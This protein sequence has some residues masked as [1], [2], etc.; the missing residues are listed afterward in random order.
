[1][2]DNKVEIEVGIEASLSG[3]INRVLSGGVADAQ[4]IEAALNGAL[5][6]LQAMQAA[7]KKMG[8]LTGAVSRGTP[9]AQLINANTSGQAAN[10]RADKRLIETFEKVAR[11]LGSGASEA[12]M[13]KA[14]REALVAEGL[15][16]RSTS[17]TS[18]DFN[19]ATLPLYQQ[20]QAGSRTARN[21][22]LNADFD[23]AQ[24]ENRARDYIEHRRNR[25][26][27]ERFEDNSMRA[28]AAHDDRVRTRALRQIE[29]EEGWARNSLMADAKHDDAVRA[30]ALKQVQKKED[31]VQRNMRA[32]A[33][34][35]DRERTRQAGF[36]D[37][38]R[39]DAAAY[40]D[41]ERT[42]DLAHKDRNLRAAAAHEDK[43]RT[44][45]INQAEKDAGHRD[46]N[47]LRAA[48]WED[49]QR[50]KAEAR[51]RKYAASM[52]RAGDL[53]GLLAR[54]NT[55]QAA[56]LLQRAR[57]TLSGRPG[58]DDQFIDGLLREAGGKVDA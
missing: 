50:M 27:G 34:Y 43:M 37:K 7:S 41:K 56:G 5:K 57:G 11:E 51:A 12:R 1:M 20:A 31:F 30:R 9:T 54:G 10:A 49:G 19:R 36:D 25:A 4:K 39:W 17:N 2:T 44:A 40:E 14:F 53:N 52:L 3:V 55:E 15:M 24:R 16:T 35:E 18:K 28:N 26:N 38:I 58:V 42:R 47:L 8:V 33:L 29:R 46:A 48:Q 6:N 13:K 23:R 32:A 22:R 21:E 45:A